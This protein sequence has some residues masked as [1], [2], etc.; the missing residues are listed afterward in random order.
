MNLCLPSTVFKRVARPSSWHSRKHQGTAVAK[1][2]IGGLNNAKLQA[3]IMTVVFLFFFFLYFFSCVFLQ[4]SF[5]K[6]K[7]KYKNEAQSAFCLATGCTTRG[8]SPTETGISLFIASALL[9]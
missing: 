6:C 8:F 5:S 2:E 9:Y 4:L 7:V 3:L 1:A